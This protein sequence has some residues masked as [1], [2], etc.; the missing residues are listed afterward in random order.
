MNQIIKSKGSLQETETKINAKSQPLNIS[1]YTI[2]HDQIRKDFPRDN[3]YYLGISPK[4]QDRP[5][6]ELWESNDC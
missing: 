4:P 2:L 6:Q 5:C 1:I 3:R